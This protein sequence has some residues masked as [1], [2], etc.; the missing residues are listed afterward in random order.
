MGKVPAGGVGIDESLMKC[1]TETV[2]GREKTG[3][4]VRKDGP[5]V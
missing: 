3:E 4:P 1:E 2:R 5:V